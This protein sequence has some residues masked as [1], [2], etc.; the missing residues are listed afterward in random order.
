MTSGCSE[1][2]GDGDCELSCSVTSTGSYSSSLSCGSGSATT[3]RDHFDAYGNPGTYQVTYA[4]GETYRCSL[5]YDQTGDVVGI[6]CTS[7]RG[8]CHDR[9]SGAAGSGGMSGAGGS[10]SSGGTQNGTGGGEASCT[11]SDQCGGD[12]VGIWNV[13]SSCLKVAGEVDLLP[14]G[15]GCATAPIT[16]GELHVTGTWAAHADG[17]Y[18]DHTTTMGEEQFTLASECIERAAVIIECDDRLDDVIAAALGYSSVVCTGTED[19]GCD[20]VATVQQEGTMGVPSLGPSTE[21]TCATS[22]H[23]VTTSGDPETKYSY[24]VLGSTMTMT[25]E[26]TG[27]ITTGMIVLEK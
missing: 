22:G 10:T 13:T 18:S 26:N 17:S 5:D 12:L 20:C 27:R 1:D 4:N 14:V 9:E 3:E 15:I 8:S 6:D 21:G 7:E 2:R 23:V 11:D 24:C 16:G 19:R 25:P